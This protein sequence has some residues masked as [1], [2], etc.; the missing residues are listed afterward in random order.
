MKYNEN[1]INNI[2]EAQTTKAFGQTFLNH[3]DLIDEIIH[4]AELNQM[5]FCFSCKD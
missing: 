1:E 4:K 3:K 2:M 5:Y